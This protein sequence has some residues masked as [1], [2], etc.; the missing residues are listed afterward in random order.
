MLGQKPRNSQ[1]IQRRSE[2]LGDCLNFLNK[3]FLTNAWS[4][5]QYIRFYGS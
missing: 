3:P 5:R 2:S 1:P 4:G